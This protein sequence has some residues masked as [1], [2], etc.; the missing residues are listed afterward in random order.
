MTPGKVAIEDQILTHVV[1]A[2]Q[3]KYTFVLRLQIASSL[4]LGDR[5]N[6]ISRYISK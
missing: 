2:T 6:V 1:L 3:Q 4:D 5:I